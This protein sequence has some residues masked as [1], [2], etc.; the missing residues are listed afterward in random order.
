MA[1]APAKCPVP[2]CEY[3]TPIALPNYDTVYKDLDLHTRYA[4]HDL[5]GGAGGGGLPKPDR[6]PRPTIGEGSTESDWV[7]FMDQWERYKR[8]TGIKKEQI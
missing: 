3:K 1:Q 4:H 2:T 6:L 8:P 7:Y 5:P